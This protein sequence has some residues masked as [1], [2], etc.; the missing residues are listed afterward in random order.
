[1]ARLA[2]LKGMIAQQG[3]SEPTV[4]ELGAIG[5][6]SI[7]A[8][9]AVCAKGLYVRL[10]I[11][12]IQGVVAVQAG[13]QIKAREILAMAVG[14][15]KGNSIGNLPV[16]C[17]RIAGRLVGKTQWVD[18][19]QRNI[20]APMLGMASLTGDFRLLG[21]QRAM[22]AG[23]ILKFSGHLDMTDQ[24]AIRHAATLHWSRVTGRAF[25]TYLRVRTYAVPGNL[26]TPFT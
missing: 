16:A 7:V 26:S 23:S 3:K 2:G 13:N 20:C 14:A 22:K 8:D 17:Q 6:Q 1:M 24:A 21:Q 25:T 15:G 5:I 19:C 10:H 12:G 4:V 9:Q 11:G 18:H